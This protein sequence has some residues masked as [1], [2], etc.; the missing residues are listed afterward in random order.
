[1]LPAASRPSAVI[2]P[3]LERIVPPVPKLVSRV[4]LTLKRASACP[5]SARGE[6]CHAGLAAGA[7]AGVQAAVGVESGYREPE[8]PAGRK[9]RV[10]L[11]AY[12]DD[13]SVRLEGDARAALATD[14]A[15][16]GQPAGAERGVQLSG[17]QVPRDAEPPLTSLPGAHGSGGCGDTSAAPAG[18]GFAQRKPT[19]AGPRWPSTK[20][21]TWRPSC[22][23]ATR[24]IMV[25]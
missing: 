11:A 23:P 1:M 13:L 14:V 17:G 9:A 3:P 5:A 12:P 8:G 7:E 15:G 22:W 4:P 6:E 25:C 10:T 24:S 2:P 21:P 16:G 20:S 18:V 19:G